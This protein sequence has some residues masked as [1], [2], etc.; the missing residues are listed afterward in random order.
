L[1]R[2]ELPVQP[3][4]FNQVD[5]TGELYTKWNEQVYR[6]LPPLGTLKV[7]F[8]SPIVLHI[9]ASL[10]N[11]LSTSENIWKPILDVMKKAYPEFNDNLVSEVSASRYSTKE[12]D[13][14]GY[15][16]KMKN[17]EKL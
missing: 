9:D 2:I 11:G 14:V 8:K 6:L 1:D 17:L 4:S 3:L 12:K 10:S 7:D 5:L 13:K 15:I 16:V